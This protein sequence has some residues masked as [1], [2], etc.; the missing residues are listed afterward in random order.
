MAVL[1]GPLGRTR[2]RIRVAVHAGGCLLTTCRRRLGSDRDDQGLEGCEELL[3]TTGLRLRPHLDAEEDG[4]G[5]EE[6]EDEEIHS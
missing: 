2:R 4:E 5:Q 6:Y 1:A 3:S